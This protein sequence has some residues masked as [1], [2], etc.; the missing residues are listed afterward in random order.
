[1]PSVRKL[2]LGSREVT[3]EFER[4]RIRN[5][6]VRVRRDGTL[7][8]SLP[9]Y[10]SV[11]EA[12]D[13]IVS[14]QDYLL[15]SID[16]V[17]SEEKTKSLSRRFIDGEVFT[18]LGNPYVLKVLE[19]AKNTCRAEDGVITL[20][21]KDPSDYRTRYMTYEKW[22]RRCIRSIIVVSIEEPALGTLICRVLIVF[23]CF[24]LNYMAQFI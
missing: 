3:V 4:K 23:I 12:E 19:G 1:M 17:V 10:A 8:C 24:F 7:Y 15:K 22:R 18:V 6:N 11:K 20:E 13:F 2:V 16:N 5:I 21:V 14:K 9:Y